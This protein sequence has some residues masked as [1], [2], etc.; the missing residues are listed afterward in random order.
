MS[1]SI[2]NPFIKVFKG[3]ET[4]RKRS[5]CGRGASITNITLITLYLNIFNTAHIKTFIGL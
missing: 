4:R 2:S 3:I 5:V 1:T